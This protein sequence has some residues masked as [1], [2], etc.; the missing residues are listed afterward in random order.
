MVLL[1]LFIIECDTVIDD[2][3]VDFAKIKIKIKIKI[4]KKK[5][6]KNGYPILFTPAFAF[7]VVVQLENMNYSYN[8]NNRKRLF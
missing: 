4:H 6:F 2:V 8:N 5:S 1:H 7:V 3:L